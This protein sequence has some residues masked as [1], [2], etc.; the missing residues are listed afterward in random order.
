MTC[1][2]GLD[3]RSDRPASVVDRMTRA[4]HSRLDESTPGTRHIDSTA[5]NYLIRRW[6]ADGRTNANA[7]AIRM[8]TLV[9][10]QQTD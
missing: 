2:V 9:V 10:L 4:V 1:T 8:D 5:F 6:S 7:A 3:P